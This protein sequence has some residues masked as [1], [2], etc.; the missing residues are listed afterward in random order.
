M[1]VALAAL[2]AALLAGCVPPALVFVSP[3]YPQAKV[4]RVV[5]AGFEDFPG[6][7]G[8]GKVAAAI[9]EKYLLL[10]GY[11]L[12]DRSQA[13]AA[14]AQEGV[15]LSQGL[16]PSAL[17]LLA[18]KLGVDAVA[19]GQLTDFTD[20]TDRTVMEDRPLE[21][22]SPIL[23]SQSVEQRYPGGQRVRTDSAMVTGYAI[24]TTDVPVQ[25]TETLDAHVGISVRL[26]DARSGEM[27]WNGSASAD[28]PRL[29]GALE[30][31]SSALMQAVV[32]RLKR[33]QRP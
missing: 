5:L 23:S 22:S 10:A 7:Q 18:D 19:Y 16:D 30:D 8:S 11:T 17:R 26:V 9:F 27:L 12:A 20:S 2:A 25:T 29:Q 31:A 33:L 1:R 6:S 13:E 4:R 28:N 24:T 21:Q 15:D 14:M 3:H 32:Q